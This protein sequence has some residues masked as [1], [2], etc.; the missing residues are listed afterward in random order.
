[1]SQVDPT[2][3]GVIAALLFGYLVVNMLFDKR[4]PRNWNPLGAGFI[5]GSPGMALSGLLPLG[6]LSIGAL[7]AQVPAA[8]LA[9]MG[10]VLLVAA[11]ESV[12]PVT[13]VIQVVTTLVGVLLVERLMASPLASGLHQRL[14]RLVFTTPLAMIMAISY[15]AL[16]RV[17]LKAGEMASVPVAIVVSVLASAAMV[18]ALG[19]RAEFWR[20]FVE[21]EESEAEEFEDEEVTSVQRE[22]AKAAQ[23]GR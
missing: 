2:L 4:R 3:M 23:T 5:I 9:I 13:I 7:E 16:G 1:M 11:S 22:R 14:R 6:P 10:H 21:K 19:K 20:E 17:D 15:Y 12:R 8:I 18:L